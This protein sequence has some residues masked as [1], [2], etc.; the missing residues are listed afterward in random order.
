MRQEAVTRGTR[1]F[2][3]YSGILGYEKRGSSKRYSYYALPENCDTILFPG[4]T[5]P[6]TRPDKVKSLF[7]HLQGTIPNLGIVL[8]CCTKPSHDLGREKHFCAMFGEMKEYLESHGVKNVL[9]ACPN[10]Y[11]VFNQYGDKLSVTTV[12]EYLTETS[13][14]ATPN[15][16]A[17]VTI[18]DPCGTRNKNQI[19]MAIRQIATEKALKIKEMEHHGS[20]TLCCGEGGS[21]GC[22]NATLAMGWGI[23]RKEEAGGKRI[24]TY[25]AGCVNF[26]GSKT[27]TSHILD[28]IFDPEATLAGKAKVSKAPWTYLNRLRLK[29]HFKKTINV[30]ACRERT[31]IGENKKKRSILQRII[32]LLTLVTVLVAVHLSGVSQY[33]E[34][35]KLQSFIEGYGSLAPLIYMLTYAVA[36]AL[37]LPGLPITIAGGIL[38]GPFWGVVYS[39]SGA[40]AGACIAFLI[41]RSLGRTWIEKKLR[42]SKLKQLDTMV[43]QHGWKAV[44]FTRLIPL[45]PFNLLNYAFGLT[46][47]KFT[48]YAVTSFICMLPACIAFIVFSSSLL[49][50][51]KGNVTPSFIIGILLIAGVSSIPLLYKK[52][53]AKIQQRDQRIK[54]QEENELHLPDSAHSIKSALTKKAKVVLAILVVAVA[55]TLLVYKYFYYLDAYLYTYEFYWL[56]NVKNLQAANIPLFA[57]FFRPMGLAT[58]AL[59]QIIHS[60]LIQN[61]Y[62]PFSK[63][64]LASAITN[65]FGLGLGSLFSLLGFFVVG[66]LSFGLGSFFLGDI[67]PYLKRDGLQKYRQTIARPTA[68]ALPLFFTIPLIPVAVI[69]IS[70]AALKVSLRQ[71]IQYMLIGLTLR[72][73]WLLT[74]PVLF[75]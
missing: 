13:L 4:C 46:R 21:V 2:S 1:D 50:V 25:C 31:F 56:F 54:Q 35:E 26:L 9:V 10:C 5:L 6:G 14:P 72:L 17:E 40:T 62:L 18:H 61:Y 32:I 57:D 12:Y 58:E 20:K 70:A 68:I 28:L 34:Q 38:F 45:F 19:H 67:L 63:P 42:S 65:A 75:S 15:I 11:R 41:S 60:N 3:D 59:P 37:F 29:S 8:D 49:D 33:L 53:H 7:N 44:A 24:L 64:I 16:P 74:M 39:I 27:P 66:L 48:H 55:A 43:E 47:V 71:I 51:L 52:N 36:P 73:C 30:A 69:A 22:V 23:R